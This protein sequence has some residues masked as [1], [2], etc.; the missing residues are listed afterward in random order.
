MQLEDQE[1]AVTIHTQLGALVRD[2]RYALVTTPQTY[3]PVSFE[4]VDVTPRP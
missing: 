2:P 4:E 3:G 1:L